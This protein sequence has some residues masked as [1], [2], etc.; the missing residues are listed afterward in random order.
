MIKENR[1]DTFEPAFKRLEEIARLLEDSSTTL[2]SS[3]QLYEEGQ[4]LLKTCQDMLDQAEKKLKL[5]KVHAD[6]HDIEETTLG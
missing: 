4:K 5:I 3:F 2:E 6:G 1:Y